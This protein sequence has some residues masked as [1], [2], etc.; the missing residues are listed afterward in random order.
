MPAETLTLDVRGMSCANCARSIEKKLASTPGVTKASVDLEAA[1]AIVEY[2]TDLV[3]P[4]AL[5]KAVRDLGYEV[6][7]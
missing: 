1:R 5:A 6:A 7:A 4:D 3:K 2:D